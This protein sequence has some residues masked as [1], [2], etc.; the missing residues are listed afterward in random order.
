MHG[1]W[2]FRY[3]YSPGTCTSAGSGVDY[4]FLLYSAATCVKQRGTSFI[5]TCLNLMV[6]PH[7]MQNE[8]KIFTEGYLQLVDLYYSTI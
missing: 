3:E 5:L 4:D 8:L 6:V 2:Q 7:S 1:L